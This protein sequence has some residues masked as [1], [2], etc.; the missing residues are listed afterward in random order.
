MNFCWGS[1]L[2]ATVLFSLILRYLCGRIYASAPFPHNHQVS[3]T[4]LKTPGYY[5]QKERD[6]KNTKRQQKWESRGKMTK[7]WA[8]KSDKKKREAKTLKFQTETLNTDKISRIRERKA[9]KEARNGADIPDNI[10]T[11]SYAGECNDHE[12]ITVNQRA[13]TCISCGQSEFHSHLICMVISSVRI[14]TAVFFVR[15]GKRK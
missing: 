13:Y 15:R 14:F 6:K 9:K 7:G 1:P 11:N 5:E 4:G 3:V 2:K 10:Y 8:K 12:M